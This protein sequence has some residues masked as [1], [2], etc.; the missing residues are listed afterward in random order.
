M[1]TRE[2]ATATFPAKQLGEIADFLDNQRRPVKE[3]DRKPG[4]TARMDSKGPSTTLSSM[5]H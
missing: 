3:A 1:I 4:I 2:L 5:S